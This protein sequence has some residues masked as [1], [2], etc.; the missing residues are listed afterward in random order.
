MKPRVTLITLGVDDLKKSLA[1]YQD[2]LGFKTQGIVGEEFEYGAVAFF[3]L[4][5]GLQL[6]LYPRESLAHDAGIPKAPNSPTEFTLAHNVNSKEEVD[7][8]MREAEKAGAKIVKEAQDAF[9]GG[10]N[11]Y[12]QDPD[13]HLWEVAWNPEM[14][15]KE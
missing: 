5:N 6:A 7:E 3:E 14:K 11:G 8:V 13:G 12:F 1:F 4:Q 10:Y 2:G 15:I 9:W